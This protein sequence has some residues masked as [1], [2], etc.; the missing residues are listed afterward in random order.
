MFDIFKEG[1]EAW[2][3]RIKSPIL[4]SI[5]FSFIAINWKVLFFVVFSDAPILTRFAFFDQ[6]TDWI[7]LFFLPVVIGVVL[8]VLSPFVNYGGSFVVK[9]P[10]EEMRILQAE[11]ASAVM[12]RKNQLAAE[13]E[14]A[15]AEFKRAALENAQATQAIDDAELDD[16]TREE[17][18]AKL[19]ERGSASNADENDD[20]ATQNLPNL[21]N[22]DWSI[23]RFAV[24]VADGKFT[25]EGNLISTVPGQDRF[26]MT[27]NE[28]H[29]GV[30]ELDDSLQYLVR[31][32]FLE[33]IRGAE[34]EVERNGYDA[35]DKLSESGV[36]VDYLPVF[37]RDEALSNE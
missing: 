26:V 1:A 15:E 31:H 21:D 2:F 29:R 36:I 23:L 12:T 13:R 22:V 10:V 32:G 20:L 33:H 4:G 18:N 8:G 17:L 14:I 37:K 11:S 5:L 35:L 3:Q 27:V 6:N 7:T 16:R 9:W 30:K 24:F 34:Y 19:S 28:G 25:R